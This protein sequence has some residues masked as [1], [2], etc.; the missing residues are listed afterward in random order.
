MKTAQTLKV[1][2]TKYQAELDQV[3]DLIHDV[4]VWARSSDKMNCEQLLIA[5]TKEREDLQQQEKELDFKVRFVDWVLEDDKPK[6]TKNAE[7]D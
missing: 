4:R 3:R 7:N 5:Q 1:A 6:E 2:R